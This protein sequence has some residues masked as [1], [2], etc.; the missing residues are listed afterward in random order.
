MVN[1]WLK[2]T[3]TTTRFVPS[4]LSTT[5]QNIETAQCEGIEDMCPVTLSLETLLDSEPQ[6]SQLTMAMP[7]FLH[8]FNIFLSALVECVP[9]ALP[10]QMLKLEIETELFGMHGLPYRR[11]QLQLFPTEMR[12]SLPHR[13]PRPG[14]GHVSSVNIHSWG[15]IHSQR[16]S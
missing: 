9:P 12:V 10:I 11:A 3:C 1:K 8:P 6:R 7:L 14:S 4:Q 13:G 15:G 16:P 2:D 5:M